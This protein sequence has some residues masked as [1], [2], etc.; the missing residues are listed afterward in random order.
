[1]QVSSKE[2]EGRLVRP[3][4]PRCSSRFFTPQGMRTR[5]RAGFATATAVAALS[6]CP[7]TKVADAFMVTPASS[8]P[9]AR[10]RTTAERPFATAAAVVTP[11]KKVA[12]KSSL[13][14]EN[15]KLTPAQTEKKTTKVQTKKAVTKSFQAVTA[16]TW[17]HL[18]DEDRTTPLHTLILGTHPSVASLER[19]QYY[20]HPL[21]YVYPA[22]V[23]SRDA[24]SRMDG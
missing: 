1:M 15:Q 13:S 18:P 2:Q 14:S 8:S 9:T 20:G 12:R 24:C 21:K 17:P 6:S 4:S 10:K 11:E 22:I 7:R 5:S 16:A 3:T 19:T 23:Y